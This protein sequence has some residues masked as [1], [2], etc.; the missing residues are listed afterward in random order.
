MGVTGYSQRNF[1]IFCLISYEWTIENQQ[2]YLR[3]VEQ[4]LTEGFRLV[5]QSLSRSKTLIFAR[6]K[7]SLFTHTHTHTHIYIY[8]VHTIRFQT[9][10]VWA[11]VL[12]VHIWNSS[13]LWSN[14]LRL[15]CT[16]C[17]V[18]TTSGRP[19]GIPLVWAC[20]WSSPLPL[21]SPQLSHND[22]LW[23]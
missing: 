9:F 15:Q 18:P 12:I 6:K 10:F 13:P 7:I 2:M 17:T 4:I 11:L 5:C 8:A 23:A 20:Q 3:I 1:E 16:C 14:L 21:S 22:S 19:H